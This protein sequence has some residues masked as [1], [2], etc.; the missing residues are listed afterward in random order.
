MDTRGIAKCNIPFLIWE[1]SAASRE[2]QMP[3]L[4]PNGHFHFVVEHQG[5]KMFP[6]NQNFPVGKF[7]QN[8]SYIRVA[9][10]DVHHSV[11]TERESGWN[12]EQ[13]PLLCACFRQILSE[14]LLREGV[15]VRRVRKPAR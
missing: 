12:P 7:L 3:I 4:C 2:H 1:H 5:R 13:C 6:S 9:F 11:C 10:G 15:S 14:P 8:N